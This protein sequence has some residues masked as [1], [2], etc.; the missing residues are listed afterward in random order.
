MYTNQ[1]VT[2]HSI[3]E[4]QFQIIQS[5][6]PLEPLIK[7]IPLQLEANLSNLSN[8]VVDAMKSEIPRAV[9]VALEKLNLDFIVSQLVSG[10]NTKQPELVQATPPEVDLPSNT[11]GSPEPIHLPQSSRKRKRSDNEN[12][13]IIQ[14]RQKITPA[15]APV[16][17]DP[18]TLD[19]A[20]TTLAAASHPGMLNQSSLNAD[21]T[22]SIRSGRDLPNPPSSE[23]AGLL[24][25]KEQSHNLL[26]NVVQTIDC[27]ADP[28]HMK[29]LTQTRLNFATQKSI[30]HKPDFGPLKPTDTKLKVPNLHLDERRS[31]TALTGLPQDISSKGYSLGN[32]VFIKTGPGSG[33]PSKQSASSPLTSNLSSSTAAPSKGKATSKSKVAKARPIK[34]KPTGKRNEKKRA[35]P[36]GAVQDQNHDEPS[37]VKENEVTK[38]KVKSTSPARLNATSSNEISVL[39]EHDPPN[40]PKQLEQLGFHSDTKAPLLGSD[41]QNRKPFASLHLEQGL[42]QQSARLSTPSPGRQG[43]SSST[44]NDLIGGSSTPDWNV[45]G[46]ALAMTKAEQDLDPLSAIPS[47]DGFQVTGDPMSSVRKLLCRAY[48]RG[49]SLDVLA[50]RLFELEVAKDVTLSSKA[51]PRAL[52]FGLM[53][54]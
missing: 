4:Q 38:A 20:R 17:T 29:R 26:N 13:D 36:P 14:S 46:A 48:F 33:P 25:Q 52:I 32:V 27:D 44:L 16:R 49:L 51:I 15:P 41:K 35:T 18:I 43:P 2:L 37:A 21:S 31:I 12:I 9:G 47:S 39:S 7:G 10:L 19:V 3:L 6:S 53:I 11:S 1:Q 34:P 42:S 40:S 54:F 24:V 22:D 5:L 23:A 30:P 45:A 28:I 8:N 50:C